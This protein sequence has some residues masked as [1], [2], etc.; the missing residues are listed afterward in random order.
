MDEEKRFE[1]I[2]KE[3]NLTEEQRRFIIDSVKAH[4]IDSYFA[5]YADGR[6]KAYREATVFL[7]KSDSDIEYVAKETGHT[8]EEVKEYINY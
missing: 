8:I 2:I 1:D 7:I 4:K 5:G 6:D 3:F